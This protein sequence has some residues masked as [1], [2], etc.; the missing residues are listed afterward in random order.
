[1]HT[2]VFRNLNSGRTD[3]SYSDF[4]FYSP[5]IAA[6]MVNLSIEDRVCNAQLVE[7]FTYCDLHDFQQ[8]DTMSG[9]LKW[10]GVL[11]VLG[12]I[13]WSGWVWIAKPCHWH[14][15]ISQGGYPPL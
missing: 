2:Y 4:S 8:S 14:E 15:H 1:M 3:L 11:H 13:L 5:T 6:R 9:L 12:M 7:L 10:L